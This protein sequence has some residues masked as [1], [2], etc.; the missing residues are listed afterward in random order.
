M[1]KNGKYLKEKSSP[2]FVIFAAT[3]WGIDAVLFRPILYNLPVPVVVFLESSIATLLMSP[4]FFLK[5]SSLQSIPKRDL[6]VFIGVA[7]FGGA[8]GTMAIVKALFYVNFVNLSIVV[9]IQKLQPIFALILASIFLKEKLP[10]Q[11][12]IWATLAI[13]GVLMLT[14]GINLTKLQTGEKTLAASLFALLAAFSFGS[15][16]VLSKRALSN[17]NFFTGTYLRFLFTS[18]LMLIIVFATGNSN[19]FEM[20]NKY[21]W[22]T[23]LVIAFS[24]GGLAILLYYFGLKKVSA[25]VATICELAFPFTAIILEYFLR[26]NMLDMVQ[27]FG[28]ILLLISILKVSWMSLVKK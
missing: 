4:F 19:N 2:I 16:T 20:V 18:I 10:K 6:L 25:S 26:G 28:A 1:N 11:F 21:Q 8:I 24:S 27:W 13:I 22:I 12:F 23:F 9:L 17:V 7:V 5:K 3:L 15:S 14:F